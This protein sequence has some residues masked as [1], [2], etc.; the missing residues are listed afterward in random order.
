[1]KNNTKKCIFIAF[2]LILF[3]LIF[4]TIANANVSFEKVENNNRNVEVKVK[5]DKKIKHVFIY[6]KSSNDK[7][8]LF[9]KKIGGNKSECICIIPEDQLSTETETNF[10]IVVVEEDGKRTTSDIKAEKLK[11]YPSM[12][13]SETAKPTTTSTP[14]P[15]KPTP[16]TTATSSSSPTT[17][18]S[19]QPTTSSSTSTSPSPSSSSS[20]STKP[21]Q[22]QSVSPDPVVNGNLEVHFI[23][24]D[25]RVD[26]IYIKA[27]DQSAFI[28]G[29]FYGDA[30]PEIAYLKRIGVTHIDYYIGSH[31]HT[32]H[33]GA[34]GPIIKEF[35]IT[36]IV[37]SKA[38]Y[39]GKPSV[40]YAALAKVKSYNKSNKTK[41]KAETDAINACKQII[42]GQ[43]DSINIGSMKVSCL[44]PTKI[45]SGVNP[46]NDS[47]ACENANSLVLRFDYGKTSFLMAGDSSSKSSKGV[48][49]HP[50]KD[51]NNKYPG[52]I[53]VDVYK[54]SHHNSSIDMAIIKLMSP[55]YV[56]F[57]TGPSSLP[58]SSYLN[59]LKNQ[60][61]KTYIA[62]KNRDKNILITS[63]GTS[64]KVKTKN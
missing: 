29:G 36:N 46:T 19:S 42:M 38:K 2:L 18:G 37:C 14:I 59:K 32:N 24:P 63:D 39:G 45:I 35:G 5:A 3:L 61:I 15:T 41:Q 56:V 10:K 43:G 33:V 53:D 11:P 58:S 47:G 57:T 54:N 64:L 44:G 48:K 34:A 9:Y 26:A 49:V 7:Y 25:S 22:S 4:Q 13:P 1:M 28:D 52:S 51:A 8:I 27:G 40:I 31:G 50:I 62:T 17:S 20:A 6:K 30:K 16:T 60:G 21:T 23:D 12:N 55:Q